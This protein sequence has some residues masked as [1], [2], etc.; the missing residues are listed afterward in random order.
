MSISSDYPSPITVNGFSCRNC[1]DVS[2]ADK[3]I[4]PAHPADGPFGINASKDAQT[5]E[6]TQLFDRDKIEAAV[7]AAQQ[8]DAS[9]APKAHAHDYGPIDSVPASGTLVNL[10]A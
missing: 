6:H 8:A 5:K 10:S 9:H 3:H 2:Y 4:D 1:T 7:K